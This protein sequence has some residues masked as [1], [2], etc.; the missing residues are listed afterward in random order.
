MKTNILL[1]LISLLTIF[2]Y[3]CSNVLDSKNND[4]PYNYNNTSEVTLS[5][6]SI[7]ENEIYG[8]I[9]FPYFIQNGLS[10]IITS[11]ELNNAGLSMN[12]RYNNGRYYSVSYFGE[13]NYL[14]LLYDK[15]NHSSDEL[16][17]VDGFRTNSSLIN[18]ADF[19]EKVKVGTSKDEVLKIDPNA[20]VHGN[21]TF[22]R[23]YEESSLLIE[24]DDSIVVNI[25]EIDGCESVLNYV[26]SQDLKLI[27]E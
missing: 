13:K 20:F 8:S 4:K 26:T 25:T 10:I 18:M 17:V 15:K 23:F 11:D 1:V 21:Q 14:F 27:S 3:G 5:D 16:I 9:S 22:H 19:K 12:M 7:L 6:N 24:Y 2:T